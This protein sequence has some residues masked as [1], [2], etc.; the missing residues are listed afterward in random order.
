MPRSPKHELRECGPR[1][2]YGESL[3]L[4]FGLQSNRS[5]TR[6]Q[7]PEARAEGMR[8]ED[9]I[10]RVPQLAVRASKQSEPYPFPKARSAS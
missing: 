3:S 6:A 5:C 1:I 9:Q 4:R 7:K 2:K 8:P 10:R